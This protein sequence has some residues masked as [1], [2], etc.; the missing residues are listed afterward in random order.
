M[1]GLPLEVKPSAMSIIQVNHIQ[2][3]CKTRFGNLVDISDVNTL[4][5]DEKENHFL[6]R[7]LA[8][9]AV[10]AAAKVEDSIAAAS[11]VD[12]PKDDG[13]DAF[14]FD[15]S[16]HICYLIQSKW[17]KNGTSTIDVGSVLK[18]IQGVNHFFAA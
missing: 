18:F 1:L 14:Y 13:I 9:F 7:A 5:P 8:A 15:R 3:S 6:T 11:V 17:V 10:A 2:S 4:A 12:E 16:E